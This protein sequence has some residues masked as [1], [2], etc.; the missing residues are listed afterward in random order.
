VRSSHGSLGFRMTLR[1]ELWLAYQGRTEGPCR[2]EDQNLRRVR[3]RCR[4]SAVTRGPSVA[5][6]RKDDCWS[7]FFYHDPLQGGR[8]LRGQTVVDRFTREALATEARRSHSAHDLIDTAN[9]PS[10]P[11]RKSAVILVGNGAEFAARFLD[12]RTHCDDV[13][14]DFGRLGQPTDNANI[15]SLKARIRV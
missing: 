6:T 7:K 15:E 14:L 2:L 8:R 9:E 11:H 13:R 3:P 4:K 10:S 12:S 5:P 1:R